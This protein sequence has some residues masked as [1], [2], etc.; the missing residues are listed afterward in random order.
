MLKHKWFVSILLLILFLAACGGENK[1]NEAGSHP[2]PP[3]STQPSD[4]K[5]E[6]PSKLE[7]SE[8][9]RA[10]NEPAEIVFTYPHNS[11]GIPNEWFLNQARKKFPNYTITYLETV[12]GAENTMGN[13]LP[14]NPTIDLIVSSF[15]ASYSNIY[16][17]D[18]QEDMN[19]LVKKYNFDLS[20][21][22]PASIETIKQMGNGELH[23]L[24]WVNDRLCLSNLL[25]SM[26]LHISIG[27]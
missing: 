2:I 26:R 21:F 8:A 1:G 3:A 11:E 16:P 15:G 22:Q 25:L 19:D 23:S 17:F 6:T 9:E 27:G 20:Q 7:Q 10:A 13:I 5:E 24:P 4:E 14:T 18:V 12:T